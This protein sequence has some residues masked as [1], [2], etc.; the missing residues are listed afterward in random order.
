MPR[1]WWHDYWFLVKRTFLPE[2]VG[3]GVVLSSLRVAV[4]IAPPRCDVGVSSSSFVPT[5]EVQ[6]GHGSVITNILETWP[7]VGALST[8]PRESDLQNTLPGPEHRLGC[9]K[10]GQGP[11]HRRCHVA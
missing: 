6:L 1:G 2:S 11:G 5:S 3:C 10:S 8:T 7:S 9:C 4:G